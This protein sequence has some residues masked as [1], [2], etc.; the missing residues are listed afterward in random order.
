MRKN[1]ELLN[2]TALLI[3]AILAVTCFTRGKVQIA[4]CLTV[5]TMWAVYVCFISA[6]PALK[7]LKYRR[8]GKRIQKETEAKRGFIFPETDMPISR[9]LLCHANHRITGFIKSLYPDASWKWDSKKPENIIVKGGVGRIKLFN[10]KDYNYA[11]IAFDENAN[12]ECDLLKIV[13]FKKAGVRNPDTE[14]K[15]N[16]R[17][18][19]D[20]QVWFEQK[21]KAVLKNLLADLN[22]RGYNRLTIKEDGECLVEQGSST[23]TTSQLEDFPK[24]VYWPRLIKVLEGAGI[25]ADAGDTVLT[26]LW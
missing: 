9:I 1:G 7:R 20:P 12:I 16:T 22:S 4:L 13:P 18:E 11:D 23:V 2:S 3:S 8:E 26:V 5:F 14:T 15:E 19:I 25:A 21:G 24:K 6:F 10:V 17:N